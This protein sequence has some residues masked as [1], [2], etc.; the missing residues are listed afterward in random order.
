M[1]CALADPNSNQA[2]GSP[3]SAA[4]RRQMGLG[5]SPAVSESCHGPMPLVRPWLESKTVK[6]NQ[7]AR[8]AGMAL[9]RI[10]DVEK[11]SSFCVVVLSYLLEGGQG[12]A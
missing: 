9:G 12:A 7:A 1:T 2:S 10:A 3:D 11:R 6:R 8:F 4:T 5:C